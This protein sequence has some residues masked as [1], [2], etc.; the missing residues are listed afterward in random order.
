MKLHSRLS[1]LRLHWTTSCRWRT[2]ERFCWCHLQS[3]DALNTFLRHTAASNKSSPEKRTNSSS[4]LHRDGICVLTCADSGRLEASL[5][6]DAVIAHR[7]APRLVA[8]SCDSRRINKCQ[9]SIKTW[10][11][12]YSAT[13]IVSLPFT[14]AR[15]MWMFGIRYWKNIDSKDVKIKA[16]WM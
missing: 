9:Q 15:L 6:P 16:K 11:H 3:T 10:L 8:L 5:S 7:R 2:C 1:H 12:I 14:G 13:L 4:S